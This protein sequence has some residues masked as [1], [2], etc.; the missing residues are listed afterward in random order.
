MKFC[1]ICGCCYSLCTG[2]VDLSCLV[3]TIR[4]YHEMQNGTEVLIKVNSSKYLFFLEA[5]ELLLRPLKDLMK[6]P[7]TK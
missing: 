2:Q 3:S 5:Y 4:W 6:D 7:K 1:D